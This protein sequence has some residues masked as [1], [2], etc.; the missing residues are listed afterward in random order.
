MVSQIVQ[1]RKLSFVEFFLNC[2]N[3]VKNES[4]NELFCE[5]VGIAQKQD[6]P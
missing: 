5:D 4:Y 1:A 3:C 2:E 6:F